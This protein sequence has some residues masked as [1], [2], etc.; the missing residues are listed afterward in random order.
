M[1][2]DDLSTAGTPIAGRLGAGGVCAP[3]SASPNALTDAKR[4]LGFLAS[5]CSIAYTIA[6]GAD[7]AFAAN[8]G[9]GSVTCLSNSAGVL[10]ALKGGAPAN[11]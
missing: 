7:G 8:D 4:S 1:L 9:S 5:A 6:R 11:I 2:I 10:L 3:R